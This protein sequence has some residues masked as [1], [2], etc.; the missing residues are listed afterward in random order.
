MPGVDPAPDRTSATW[1]GFLRSPAGA[2]LA[3]GFF[4]TVTL[5][6]T[7]LHV[8]AITEHATWRIRILGVTPH[9]LRAGSLTSMVM[10]AM[11]SPKTKRPADQ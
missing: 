4:E 5:T 10:A 8:L 11:G 3:C 7:R 9:P 2:L 6:G 1:A